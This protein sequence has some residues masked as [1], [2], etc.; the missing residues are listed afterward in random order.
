MLIDTL[1]LPT[2]PILIGALL[3]LTFRSHLNTQFSEAVFYHETALVEK[4]RNFLG[5]RLIQ[6]KKRKRR[7]QKK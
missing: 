2:L 7:K 4:K 5:F 3:L 1:P 6:N